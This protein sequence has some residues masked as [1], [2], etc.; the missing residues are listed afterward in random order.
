[1]VDNGG[2]TP[3][4]KLP[5]DE[6]SSDSSLN[7][8][9][10]TNS[11]GKDVTENIQPQLEVTSS[12][13]SSNS[14]FGKGLG[15]KPFDF[16]KISEIYDKENNVINLIPGI[17]LFIDLLKIFFLFILLKIKKKESKLMMICMQCLIF[18]FSSSS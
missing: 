16:Q 3:L 6:S 13:I 9:C 18:R 2:S 4:N 10:V 5:I 7:S 1:M 14:P 12:Q 15:K 17:G 8:S 11:G